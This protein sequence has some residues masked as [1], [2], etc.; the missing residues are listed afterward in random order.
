[1]LLEDIRPIVALLQ[2]FGDDVLQGDKLNPAIPFLLDVIEMP[3]F[4]KRMSLFCRSVKT[5]WSE[6]ILTQK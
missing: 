6:A 5:L 1:M 4:S 3:F 2:L